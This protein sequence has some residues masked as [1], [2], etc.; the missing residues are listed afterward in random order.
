MKQYQQ[1][2]SIVSYIVNHLKYLEFLISRFSLIRT[3][4]NFQQMHFKRHGSIYYKVV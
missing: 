3:F 4:L 2:K 1:V